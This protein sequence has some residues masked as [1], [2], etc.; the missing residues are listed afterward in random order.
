MA[1]ALVLLAGAGLLMK[2]TWRLLHV[3][4]GFDPEGVLTAEVSLPAHKYLDEKL[5]RA[6]SPAATAKAAAFFDELLAGVRTLPGV[7][8]AGAISALPLA[9][10]NWG[11]RIVLWDRPLPAH[12]DELPDI[13]SRVVAEDN[14][15]PL[16]IRVRGRVFDGRDPLQAPLVAIVNQALVRRDFP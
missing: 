5:A 6:L 9:G 3:D 10:D 7:Q 16:G 12:A 14:F 15:R 2:S 1:L 11:K 13:Q 4:P 8:G